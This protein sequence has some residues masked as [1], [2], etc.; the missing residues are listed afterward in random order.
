MKLELPSDVDWSIFRVA[1][2]E[3]NRTPLKEIEDAWS[4]DDLA[5]MND[6]YDALAAA[7]EKMAAQPD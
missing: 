2:H 1:T 6:V 5:R 4:I 7:E 3:R